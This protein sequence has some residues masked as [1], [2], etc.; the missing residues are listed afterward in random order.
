MLHMERATVRDLHLNTSALVKSVV[1][2][3]TF[4]IERHGVP[5]AELR[6]ISESPVGRPLPNREAFIRKLRPSKTDSGRML[7]EDRT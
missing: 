7:E 5:V 1:G 3:Q 2:G 4:I 6:P